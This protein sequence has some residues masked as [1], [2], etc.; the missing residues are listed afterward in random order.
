MRIS[1]IL[2][3]LPITLVISAC[4]QDF[5]CIDGDDFG[6]LPRFEIDS[7]AGQGSDLFVADDGAR[8]DAEGSYHTMRWIDTGY[9]TDNTGRLIIE[10]KGK[11]LPY[12]A[13]YGEYPNPEDVRNCTTSDM[14]SAPY[15]GSGSDC[16]SID[17]LC[18]MTKGYGAYLLFKRLD[19]P[20]PNKD[21]NTMRNP[22]SPTVHLYSSDDEQYKIEEVYDANCQTIPLSSGWYIYAKV[23]D[24]YYYDNSGKYEISVR[25]GVG[26]SYPDLNI[27]LFEKTRKIIE[28]YAYYSAEVI[29]K[30]VTVNPTM[31]FLVQSMIVLYLSI[32]GIMILMGLLDNP[33]DWFFK[34]VFKFL[35]ILVI[36]ST[37][38]W[39]IMYNF[40]FSI[41]TK[42]LPYLIMIINT[43]AGLDFDPENP[44]KFMDDMIS[45]YLFNKYV[46]SYK[47]PAMIIGDIKGLLLA[48][49]VI[50]ISILATIVLVYAFVVYCTT[51]IGLA[52][53]MG[54]IPILFLGILFSAL[55][56][57]FDNSIK[58]L[59]GL[60][61]QAIM[62]FVIVALIFN[63]I[64]YYFTR[65]MGF[66]VCYRK[67][68][69]FSMCITND[70]CIELLSLKGYVPSANFDPYKLTPFLINSD[71]STPRYH[72]SREGKH[73]YVPPLYKEKDYR[74]VDLPYLD[75][76]Q[77]SDTEIDFYTYPPLVGGET[78]Y[79]TLGDDAF[80]IA[81]M[82]RGNLVDLIDCLMIIVVITVIWSMKNI[83]M[84][85]GTSIAG[86]TPFGMQIADYLDK[87]KFGQVANFAFSAP[88]MVPKGVA[89]KVRSAGSF[90]AGKLE[91]KDRINRARGKIDDFA[92]DKLGRE[93][94]DKIK[95][96]ASKTAS[97][98]GTIG[99]GIG[100]VGSETML[101]VG[102]A[103]DLQ[104]RYNR[105]W[106]FRYVD[107]ARAS[108]N[109]HLF[110]ASGQYAKGFAKNLAVGAFEDV[111]KKADG[112]SNVKNRLK[113]FLTAQNIRRVDETIKIR[114]H[115]LGHEQFIHAKREGISFDDA[116][117]NAQ[118]NTNA[119]GPVGVQN[120]AFGGPAVPPGLGAA[121]DYEPDIG[122]MD[123][124]GDISYLEED[125]ALDDEG[126]FF[127]SDDEPEV[128]KDNYEKIQ[129]TIGKMEKIEQNQ[130]EFEDLMRQIEERNKSDK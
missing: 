55:K 119:P 125:L 39:E 101:T 63:I 49:M 17:N 10:T 88:F 4:S 7:Y 81:E 78:D 57:T 37:N 18:W 59:V 104:E 121:N 2:L 64:L 127:P 112:T 14:V 105:K 32:S 62:M 108:V 111:F 75:P 86:L 22:V 48:P 26:E 82:F 122:L 47:I 31:K 113:D 94:V 27:G 12:G 61:F 6:N 83:I 34:T 120:L 28:G 116:D 46:W 24:N 67:Y 87:I 9:R 19:D 80:I 92:G 50:V 77:S 35:L 69:S 118:L 95:S 20:E 58:L 42:G 93:R 98:T 130:A 91:L 90:V 23:N 71:F 129:E 8:G 99:K 85:V 68:F 102:L 38:G 21:I 15:C 79:E 25:A 109:Y 96:V 44:F 126:G 66:T 13:K 29:F 33:K 30:A 76:D 128:E 41:F 1:V 16:S 107:H 117:D 100:K 124:L 106:A 114:E 73:I 97:I 54:I 89:S 36:Y 56:V 40:F 43:S 74:M 103:T 65:I 123:G 3:L 72:F 53:I 115:F 60:C 70:S 5:D 11:W 51:V 45:D 52:L 110:D 84:R